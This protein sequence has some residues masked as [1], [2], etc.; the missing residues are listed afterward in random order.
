MAQWSHLQRLPNKGLECWPRR[1][2]SPARKGND[3]VPGPQ[4]LEI[5]RQVGSA[6][7][8]FTE[9][10]RVAVL[11]A[12]DTPKNNMATSTG[13]GCDDGEMDVLQRPPEHMF[14]RD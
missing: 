8:A 9:I 11:V 6:E 2:L 13:N 12:D 7:Q 5:S 4:V 3:G 10:H 1:N 14:M